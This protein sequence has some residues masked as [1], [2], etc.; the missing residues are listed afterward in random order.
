[1]P[2]PLEAKKEMLESLLAHYKVSPAT[3][4]VLF[5]YADLNLPGADPI[6]EEVLLALTGYLKQHT[7]E[8]PC[9]VTTQ[10]QLQ[11]A[12]DM[13]A[14]HE[15]HGI[16]LVALGHYCAGLEIANAYKFVNSIAINDYIDDFSD[17]L[18]FAHILNKYEFITKFR[19]LGCVT[20]RFKEHPDYKKT[21]LLG[22]LS[23]EGKPD[24]KTTVRTEGDV[25]ELLDDNSL[26]YQIAINLKRTAS[27][28]LKGEVQP[29][30]P[31]ASGKIVAAKSMAVMQD[32]IKLVDEGKLEVMYAEI[33]QEPKIYPKSLSFMWPRE[34]E[35]W[36]QKPAV[37]P[38]GAAS[39]VASG[40]GPKAPGL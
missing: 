29:M 5:G 31:M 14:T 13:L 30:F 40:A 28:C 34:A 9:L 26:L 36:R 35:V 7:T 22:K 8:N 11:E 16:K 37:A 6:D 39:E 1:M 27:I 23:D 20:A 2:I 3:K 17:H 24:I 12:L 10:E 21:N 25:T 38:G 19:A 33:A 18:Y 4:M 15:A 32:D